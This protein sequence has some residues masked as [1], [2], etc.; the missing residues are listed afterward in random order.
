V[1]ASH[2]DEQKPPPLRTLLTRPVLI[3]VTN[4]A[5]VS[6][7]QTACI[8]LIPLVWSTSVEFGGLSLSP[9]SIGLWMSVYGIVD[10]TC[11]YAVF[12]RLVARFGL[13]RVFLTCIASCAVMV[14]IFP[15]EN[16]V[17]RHSIR[18][19]TI[20]IWSLVMLQL[21]SMSIVRMG[22]SA[23]SIYV[24]TATPN[25]RSLGAV[26]GLARTVASVQCAVGPAAAD[27]LFAF[28]I[29]NNVFGGNLAYVVMLSLV[30]LGM[31]I[32]AQLPRHMWTHGG[33]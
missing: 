7:L 1:D 27:S 19:Q 23:V 28:S 17:L 18:G 15:L 16:I 24:S 13:R 4:Y 26:N 32:A 25:R 8:A 22:Y 3:S 10:G 21:S 20:V 9:V 2:K 11:Q 29:T 31:S 30:G 5:V 14:I 6:F 12:P 33:R